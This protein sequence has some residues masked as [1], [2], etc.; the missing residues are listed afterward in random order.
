MTT[1]RYVEVTCDSCGETADAI[2]PTA[3]AARADAREAGWRVSLPGGRDLCP[4]CR[5]TLPRTRR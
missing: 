1:Y 5:P 3:N 4:A 2:A